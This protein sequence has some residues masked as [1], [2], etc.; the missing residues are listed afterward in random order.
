[1]TADNDIMVKG[2]LDCRLKDT[3]TPAQQFQLEI[4]LAKISYQEKRQNYCAPGACCT[5]T[6]PKAL[7]I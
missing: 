2:I 5:S 7:K 1:M 6:Q 3:N 4:E